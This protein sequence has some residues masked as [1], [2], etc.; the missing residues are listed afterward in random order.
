M[1]KRIML[2]SAIIATISVSCAHPKD[3]PQA[4]PQE[5]NS[6][7]QDLG[8]KDGDPRVKVLSPQVSAPSNSQG[9]TIVIKA[10]NEAPPVMT[11]NPGPSSPK[12]TAPGFKTTVVNPDSPSLKGAAR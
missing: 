7:A 5:I 4:T 1:Q 2:I 12:P 8:M 11:V 6:L 3:Q 10:S 9:S